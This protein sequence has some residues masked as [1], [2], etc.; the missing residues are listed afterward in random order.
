MLW[1]SGGILNGPAVIMILLSAG[2][3]WT[4]EGG[5]CSQ[6]GHVEEPGRPPSLCW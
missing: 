4:A 1:D 5:V 2:M 3:D 6:Q